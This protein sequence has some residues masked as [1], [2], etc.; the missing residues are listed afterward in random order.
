MSFPAP[1]GRLLFFA[2]AVA[3]PASADALRP[4][5][6]DCGN[7]TAEGTCSGS[8]ITYCDTNSQP[9]VLVTIDCTSQFGP[10]AQCVP[11]MNGQRASCSAGSGGPCLQLDAAGNMMSIACN[12]TQP[13]CLQDQTTSA[14]TDM[15]GVCQPGQVGSCVAGNRLML[16]CRVDGQPWLLDCPAFGATCG[17]GVCEG[18]DL[19][20]VCGPDVLCAAPLVCGRL[21]RCEAAPDAG[22]P[23]QPDA[24]VA[25]DSGA[26][27]GETGIV[28]DAGGGVAPAPDAAIV[29]T[30]VAA[31]DA[32]NGAPIAPDAAVSAGADAAAAVDGGK[33]DEEGTSS[34][35]CATASGGDATLAMM[36]VLGLFL[37]RRRRA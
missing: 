20:A 21:S 32:T 33:L 14:C 27:A 12:G 37:A 28:E 31:P 24:G 35:G 34:C 13:G 2:C 26:Q 15:L 30:G 11:G 1:L 17:N 7:V 9:N 29:D 10:N 19:G 36:F 4:G 8:V 18:A 22:V 16:G 5:P 6:Q 3:L 23:V 25:R